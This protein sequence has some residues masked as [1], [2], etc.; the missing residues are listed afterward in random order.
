MGDGTFENTPNPNSEVYS[1]PMGIGVA[2]YDNDGLVDFFFSNTGTTAPPFMARGDLRDDQVYH[3]E[4]ILFHNDGGFS[5]T[6]TAEQTKLAG[7]EFSWGGIFEDFNLDGRADLAVSENYV[8]LTPHKVESLR[9]PGRFLVQNQ[10]GEFAPVGAQAGV[11]NKRFSLSTLSA[12]FNQDGAPDLVHVNLAGKSK[13]FISNN[14]TKSFVKVQLPNTVDSV[15]AM[16][17]AELSDGRTIYEPFVKGEGLC[18]DSSPMV[19]IGTGGATVQS[20]EVKYLSGRTE[21]FTTPESGS[22]L[23]S[24]NRQ[25]TSTEATTN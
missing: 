10:S 9:L 20:V 16:V 25:H 12:D 13:A 14:A 17:K 3:P 15:S 4:W 5:F 8:G 21:T 23:V 2:D 1:Y 24:R 22:T 7:Y 19:T 6:D 18:S 11:V